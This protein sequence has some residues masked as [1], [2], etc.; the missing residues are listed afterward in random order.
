[1]SN[2]ES[3]SHYQNLLE[4]KAELEVE[5]VDR[6]RPQSLLWIVFACTA[7]V[8]FALSA[9][10]LGIIS[11][12]GVSAKFL[13][14]FGYLSISILILFFKNVRFCRERSKLF[15]S[16]PEERRKKTLYATLKDSCYYDEETGGYKWLGFFLSFVCGLLN[17]GG[18]FSIIFCF[19][20]ALDSLM[21]QGILTSMFTLGSIIVL[22]GSVLLLKEHV[23]FSEVSQSFVP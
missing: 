8:C 10:I 5:V 4:D 17:L 23:R 13:N 12:G 19:Q 3:K 14:S 11:V 16:H 20:H 18:E 22:L 1:M 6:H 21:N 2:Q 15:E 7:T 9:Y